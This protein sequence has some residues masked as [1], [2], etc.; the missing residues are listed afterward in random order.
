MSGSEDDHKLFRATEQRGYG[1]RFNDPDIDPIIAER[2][3]D[4]AD[5]AGR[6]TRCGRSHEACVMNS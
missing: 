4:V 1:G 3:V 2:V 5:R 6:A